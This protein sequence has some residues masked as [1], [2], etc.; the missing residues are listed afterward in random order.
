MFVEGNKIYIANDGASIG[1]EDF[2]LGKTTKRQDIT[3]CLPRGYFG[4]GLTKG[5]VTLLRNG[6]KIKAYTYYGLIEPMLEVEESE[7]YGAIEV[8]ALRVTDLR[9]PFPAT[10]F[11]IQGAKVYDV[12]DELRSRILEM[13]DVKTY[14]P[15]G[16]EDVFLV[17]EIPTKEQLAKMGA[18]NR[19]YHRGI[20]ITD[21]ESIFA[22]NFCKRELMQ[23]ESRND[24]TDRYELRSEIGWFWKHMDRV[25][26]AKML[27]KLRIALGRDASCYE[28]DIS[29]RD[30][31][32]KDVWLQAWKELYGDRYITDKEL[33]YLDKPNKFVLVPHALYL[34][35][36]NA[37]VPSEEEAG[38][39]RVEI[40]RY[41]PTDEELRRLDRAMKI[42]SI[43]AGKRTDE[44]I[45]IYNALKKVLPKNIYSRAILIDKYGNRDDKT[46]ELAFVWNRTI[47]NLY[48]RDDVVREFNDIAI[49]VVLLHEL[50]HTKEVGAL[51][52]FP[53]GFDHSKMYV[54]YESILKDVINMIGK[55]TLDKLIKTM[56]R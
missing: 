4:T 44:S 31:V 43:F 21:I 17:M 9:T 13:R 23:Q 54:Y 11:E 39:E 18:K 27:I 16:I 51:Y 52:Q 32:Y 36:K 8:I 29:W 55:R 14:A 1:V 26:L 2:Y 41:Y 19:G 50:A 15:E 49:A 5:V 20:Y 10:I 56:F 38:L 12:F 25:D 40:V 6:Y 35:L 47:N 53:E 48:V 3:P 45:K 34:F 46:G 7:K 30:P 28:D 33:V 22:Y 24:F 37:G 42:A